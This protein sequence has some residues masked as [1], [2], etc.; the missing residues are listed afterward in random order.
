MNWT[1]V[2]VTI[3]AVAV[4]FTPLY[5]WIVLSVMRIPPHIARAA[6]PGMQI[7]TLWSAAIGVRRF[8]QGVLIR[9]GRTRWIGIGTAARL[10]LV[11]RNGNRTCADHRGSPASTSPP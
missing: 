5:L 3:V 9:Y 8:L 10:A 2:F 7:M 6:H 1:N 4:A 11:G